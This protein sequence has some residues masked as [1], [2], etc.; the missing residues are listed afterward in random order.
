[1]KEVVIYFERLIFYSLF[2]KLIIFDN[3]FLILFIYSF[4]C[5]ELHCCNGFSLVAESRDYSPFAVLGL[6]IVVD[7][8]VAK[9]RFQSARASVVVCGPS[10]CSSWVLVWAQY[11]WHIKSLV[12]PQHV[13]SSQDQRSNL[14]LLHWQA[15]SLP[16]SDQFSS[17]QSLQQCPFL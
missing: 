9:H 4:G 15:N 6:L 14:C 2:Y 12:A 8:L 3:L 7:S 17:V 13:V 5:A 11:L 10:S 1:M 16:L